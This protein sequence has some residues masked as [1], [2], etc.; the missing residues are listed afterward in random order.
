[1]G[2]EKST[3]KVGE[4]REAYASGRGGRYQIRRHAEGFVVRYRPPQDYMREF[5]DLDD[6]G[7]AAT[8]E[9]AIALAQAHNENPDDPSDAP[10]LEAASGGEKCR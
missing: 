8:Q 6:I 4:K 7:M 10:S 5:D 3:W 9:E 2:Y 1:L